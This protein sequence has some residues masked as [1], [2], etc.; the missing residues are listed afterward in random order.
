M[1]CKI[2]SLCFCSPV[3]H[4][5]NYLQ[6][7]ISGVSMFG[8]LNQLADSQGINSVTAVPMISTAPATTNLARPTTIPTTTTPG[9]STVPATTTTAIQTVTRPISMITS[10]TNILPN[11]QM[12]DMFVDPMR[13][14]IHQSINKTCDPNLLLNYA[15]QATN[16]QNFEI[17]PIQKCEA[18]ISNLAGVFAGTEAVVKK[19]EVTVKRKSSFMD[20]SDS[21]NMGT[22]LPN[23]YKLLFN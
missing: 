11:K 8:A 21:D 5:K 7:N 20:A 19:L 12:L 6:T 4:I 18:S 22:Y 13:E 14:L 17:I 16:L 9:I 3:A 10:T 1:L 15:N 23:I 2:K